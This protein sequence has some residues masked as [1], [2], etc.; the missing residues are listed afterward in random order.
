MRRTLLRPAAL[1]AATV[2]ALGSL[3]AC[4][5]DDPTDGASATPTPTRSASET[6][7]T[8]PTPSESPSESPTATEA[9]AAVRTG[10]FYVVD[11]RAGLR[12]ARERRQVSG[13]DPVRAAVEAMVQGPQDPDY[14]TTWNP[15]TT[16]NGVAVRGESIDVD[17]SA[18]ARTANV[19]SPGAA[20]MIQQLVWTAT[21]A[22][23][24]PEGRVRLLID[25]QPAGELWG[26][27]SWDGP[28]DR[29]D[30]LDVRMLVQIDTPTEGAEVG[31]PVVVRGEGAV[32][33][34]T[35]PWRVL[36]AQGRVVKR[37]VTMTR[38]GMAFSPY[39]FRVTL[40]PGTYT[41]EVVEDDP[42]GGE[43]GTPMS[44]SKTITVR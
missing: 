33:E 38:E 41:V 1:V 32:F 6:P 28:I 31:S 24:A 44:D 23:R 8:E 19:G 22:A 16:V 12:L 21:E 39:R 10:V 25:G 34:A 40:A 27:V 3:A 35:V 15:E 14:T 9:P 13:D 11:T 29:D 17:L 37:G 2:L 30:P 4:G 36:N 5:D 43:G 18:E 20:M 7:S 26:A 42:S